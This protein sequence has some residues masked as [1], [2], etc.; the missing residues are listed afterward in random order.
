MVRE[1]DFRYLG[2]FMTLLL[3]LLTCGEIPSYA[4]ALLYSVPNIFYKRKLTPSTAENISLI[5]ITEPSIK[6]LPEEAIASTV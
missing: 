5:V 1:T 2:K 6:Q 4:K 3:T